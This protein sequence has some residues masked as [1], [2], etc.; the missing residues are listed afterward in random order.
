MIGDILYELK[1]IEEEIK[2][3]L[4]SYH[5]KEITT[6]SPPMDVFETENKIKIYLDLPGFKAS[7]IKIEIENRH[8]TVKGTKKIDKQGGGGLNFLCLERKF[9]TFERR[10]FLNKEPDL[11]HIKAVLSK[12]VLKITIPLLKEEKRKKV[13][14]IR[15]EE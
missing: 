12:G 14:K 10:I 3:L 13:I 2:K 4:A 11:D 8:L 9:G 5:K 1:H 6:F 15:Q 7:D